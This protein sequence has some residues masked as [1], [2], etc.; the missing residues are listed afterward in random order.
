MGSS[1]HIEIGAE[2]VVH[3]KWLGHASFQIKTMDKVIYIDLKKIRKG[4]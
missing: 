4:S 1:A 2:M 3:V